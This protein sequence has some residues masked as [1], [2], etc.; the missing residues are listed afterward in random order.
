MAGER[1]MPSPQWTSTRPLAS[2]A[3]RMNAVALRARQC[4]PAASGPRASDRLG[5]EADEVLVERVPHGQHFIDQ[6]L[7]KAGFQ[8]KPARDQ[9]GARAKGDGRLA[10]LGDDEDVRDAQR[11]QRLRRNVS[12]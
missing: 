8:E 11:L 3:E 4:Q 12:G 5:K 10:V 9:P 6:V 7:G 2:R 1:L